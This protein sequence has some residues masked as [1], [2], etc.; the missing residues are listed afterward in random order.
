[1]VYCSKCGT[2]N[3]DTELSAATAAH[4]FKQHGNNSTV[5]TGGTGDT[6][7]NT[8]TEEDTDTVHY[9]PES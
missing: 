6:E 7:K 1:M 8:T 9:S 5:H 4:P 3:P 2:L